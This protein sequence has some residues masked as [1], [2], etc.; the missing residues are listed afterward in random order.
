MPAIFRMGRNKKY[1]V[2]AV[3][4]ERYGGMSRFATYHSSE[5]RLS[6]RKP[7]LKIVNTYGPG[8][9]WLMPIFFMWSFLC[10]ATLLLTRQVSCL[11]VHMAER[12]S[13]VRKGSLI[14]LANYFNVPVIVHL[15]AAEF[16]TFY[17]SLGDRSQAAV[18]DLLSSAAAIVT[19]GAPWKRYLVEVV[20]VDSDRVQIIHNG[21]PD[22]ITTLRSDNYIE[23][24]S[25]I[26]LVFLGALED[27]KG[28]RELI[29]ALGDPRIKPLNWTLS[30]AGNGST[31]E[32][33]HLSNSH[34]LNEKIQFC[35]W[36]EQDE[37]RILLRRSQVFVLPSHNEG[38]PLALLEA[39]AF[40]L[41]V[42]TT[43]VGAIGEAVISG[44]NG[45]L[46][47][48]RD[49]EALAQ[50]ILGLL[51]NKDEI[52]RL[53]NSARETFVSGFDVSSMNDNIEM[54]VQRVTA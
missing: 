16:H 4:F 47:P 35:G 49:S 24:E 48:A 6:A 36:L 33:E 7:D 20:G 50:A 28:L 34:G 15:H 1:L 30:I 8:S 53:G 25:T 22:P 43:P 45:L 54:L 51:L 10:L 40:G 31:Q 11:H 44:V 23:L 2:S 9:T 41:A 29:D 18:G 21:V 14:K 12:L 32:W 19:L 37:S 3:P 39:M 26:N 46:V 38:L 27:R 13:V 17:S 5:W 42:V 52:S